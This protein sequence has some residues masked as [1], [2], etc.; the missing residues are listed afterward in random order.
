MYTHKGKEKASPPRP[1]HPFLLGSLSGSITGAPL[2]TEEIWLLWMRGQHLYPLL[3]SPWSSW[4]DC[5]PLLGCLCPGNKPGGE[6]TPLLQGSDGGNHIAKPKHKDTFPG[7]LL[8]TRSGSHLHSSPSGG[9]FGWVTAWAQRGD[10]Y[11]KGSGHLSFHL[12]ASSKPLPTRPAWPLC[13]ALP[14][15]LGDH[16]GCLPGEY[17]V[18]IWKGDRNGARCCAQRHPLAREASN[19]TLPF[20]FKECYDSYLPRVEYQ[21]YF[22]TQKINFK[23]L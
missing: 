2:I 22:L 5:L 15:Q 20:A 12:S 19:S 3:N 10:A 13:C 7:N 21:G 1:P 6:P 17:S 9:W 18:V 11:S 4:G 16:F 23:C 8:R 14:R